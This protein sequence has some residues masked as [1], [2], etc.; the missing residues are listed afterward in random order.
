MKARELS[1]R[2]RGG[3][4]A[5]WFSLSAEGNLLVLGGTVGGSSI[6][7]VFTTV[8]LILF[9]VAD[10]GKRGLHHTATISVRQTPSLQ[11]LKFVFALLF[12]FFFF[13]FLLWIHF[14]FFSFA[15]SE[16][17]RRGGYG[18]VVVLTCVLSVF[19][20]PL[21]GHSAP[22]AAILAMCHTCERQEK[23]SR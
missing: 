15:L 21:F 20:T 12:L 8:L 23:G 6:I 14:L 11:Y 16:W 17:E 9:V 19:T 4:V 7:A 13:S 10:E 18:V 22:P 5:K 1:T 2:H 3:R